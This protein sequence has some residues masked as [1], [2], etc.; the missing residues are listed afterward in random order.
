MSCSFPTGPTE[1]L[2]QASSLQWVQEAV[3]FPWNVTH[4]FYQVSLSQKDRL[5]RGVHPLSWVLP[6]T[7]WY[8][9]RGMQYTHRQ[10]CLITHL[11]LLLLRLLS[12]SWKCHWIHI[13]SCLIGSCDHLALENHC[14]SR[15][16]LPGSSELEA[17]LCP[18][19][20]EKPRREVKHSATLLKTV[21]C[22]GV[23]F[24]V[25]QISGKMTEIFICY[26]DVSMFCS[27]F[28]NF[29]CSPWHQ[30]SWSI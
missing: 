6:H 8:L 15:P 29:I 23:R 5:L 18:N 28:L 13:Q 4:S 24:C 3:S 19:T 26:P 17:W 27:N 20:Q 9:F 2:S 16:V 22:C 25:N 1:L 11:L 10:A 21:R 7:W 12:I 30:D 14:F